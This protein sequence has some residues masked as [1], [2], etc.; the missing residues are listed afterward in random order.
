MRSGTTIVRPSRTRVASGTL[1]ASGAMMVAAL[2]AGAHAQSLY[3]IMFRTGGQT[4]GLN[5]TLYDVNPA[6]GAAS[7]PRNVNVNNSVGIAID[8]ATGVMYGLTDQFGR[9]NNVSGQ[10][11][12]NLLFTINPANGQATAVGRVDPTGVFQVFEG[13]IAFNP[14]DG[15]MWGVTTLINSARL[16]TINKATGLATQGPAILPQIG[17]D[18]DI[19]ALAFDAAGNLYALDTRFPNNPGPALLMRLNPQTGEVL[20]SWNTGMLLGNVAGMTFVA[21]GE[22][23]IADGDTSGTNNLYRFALST[24]TMTTIGATGAAGGIY[25]GLAGLAFGCTT[26]RCSPSDIAGANQTPAPC[27]D[28]QLTADDIIVYLA[29][30][31]A[32]DSRADVAGANQA[33]TPDGQFTADDIIVFLGRF[34][35]GC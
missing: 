13:D 10:G 19:S 2:A 25:R 15:S 16:F 1:I 32:S 18:L 35:A 4:S 28:G 3:G 21:P 7:N 5:P 30:Y 8:P 31:F 11:G 23:L 6:T 34:F 20:A 17:I 27:G 12:K 9:I 14:V 29:W 26:T 24:S 33:T 22:L